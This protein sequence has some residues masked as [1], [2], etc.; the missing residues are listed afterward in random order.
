MADSKSSAPAATHEFCQYFSAWLAQ[1]KPEELEKIRG[2]PGPEGMPGMRGQ[3]GPPG[4]SD[5]ETK[6]FLQ[7]FVSRLVKL[8]ERVN[9]VIKK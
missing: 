5:T 2:P 9:S 4:A 7:M 1:A 6:Q 3:P 8:E